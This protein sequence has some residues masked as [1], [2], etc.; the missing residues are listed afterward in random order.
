MTI[1]QNSANQRF[2][3]SSILSNKERHPSMMKPQDQPAT[4]TTSATT[5]SMFAASTL[6]VAGVQKTGK[7]ILG[8]PIKKGAKGPS[9]TQPNLYNQRGGMSSQGRGGGRNPFKPPYYIYH[10]NDTNHRIKDCLIFLESKRKMEQ[11]SNQP[12]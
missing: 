9:S 8:D 10:D 6:M 3:T 11:D 4:T 5:S 12:L 2:F 1:L 7:R